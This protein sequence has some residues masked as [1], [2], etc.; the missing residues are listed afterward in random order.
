MSA[1]TSRRA[2]PQ[3]ATVCDECRADV[4]VV[5]RLACRSPNR[6]PPDCIVRPVATF[7]KCVYVL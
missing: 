2:K 3:N 7:V 6:G 4:I 5:I 1:V